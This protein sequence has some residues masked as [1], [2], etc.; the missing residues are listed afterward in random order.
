MTSAER[1]QIAEEIIREI[2]ATQP[3][4]CA[5]VQDIHKRAQAGEFD[6]M[7]IGAFLKKRDN[8]G[9]NQQ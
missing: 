1:A 8:L 5:Q 7:P 9:G 4:T 3:A 2:D 6:G